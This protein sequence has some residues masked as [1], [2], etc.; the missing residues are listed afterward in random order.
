MRKGRKRM[1]MGRGVSNIESTTRM[2]RMSYIVILRYMIQ[3][4]L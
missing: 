3:N 1:R 2:S 4:D